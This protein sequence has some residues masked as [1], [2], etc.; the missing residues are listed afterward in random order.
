MH[1]N[2]EINHNPPLVSILVPIY[3]VELYIERCARS[4]FEQTYYNL[5]FIFC[6]DCSPDNSIQILEEVMNDYPLRSEQIRIIHHE[7]NRGSAAARNTL[8]DNSKGDF[9]FWV[10]SD[11]WVETNAVEVLVKKQR[12]ID[13][14][15]V[16]GR[17]YAHKSD[18]TIRCHDGWDLDK[19]TLMEDIIRC[20]SGATLW[21]RL[22]RKSLFFDYGIA[23]HEGINGREDYSVIILLIYYAKEVAGIDAIVYHYNLTNTHSISFG[24]KDLNF[25]CQYLKSCEII[26]TFFIGKNERIYRLC[27]EMMVKRA[28]DFMMTQYRYRYQEGYQFMADFITGSDRQYWTMISWKNEIIRI[29]ERNYYLMCM[30][31]PIRQLRSKIL[32]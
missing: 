1:V 31:Y 14:D 12:E 11:D 23:F 7:R 20:K 18:R 19:D 5:E 2:K 9:L 8:I 26:A 4:L 27:M 21:R 13:A 17:A 10:D 28:H 29:I 16:T 22:I 3:N 6:D 15:I 32:S 24:Y 30:T 25:Q